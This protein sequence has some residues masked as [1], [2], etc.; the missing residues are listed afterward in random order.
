MHLVLFSEKQQNDLKK[1][2]LK[3]SFVVDLESGKNAK[4]SGRTLMCKS[5]YKETCNV[6]H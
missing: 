4:Q 6:H 1:K 5:G 3:F 2:Y